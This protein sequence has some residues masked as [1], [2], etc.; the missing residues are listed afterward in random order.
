MPKET[1][2][3]KGYHAHIYFDS[4]TAETARR[5]REE[6][7]RRFDIEMGRFH[8]KPVGPHP[9]FSYQVAFAPELFGT[10]IPWLALNR[11]GLTV[12]VHAETGDELRDH[13]A[14]VFWLGESEGL[15]LDIFE[16]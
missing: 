4:E 3:I 11:E 1:S 14:H 8:E 9:R 10:F 12:F 13:T 7:E 2:E 15:K 16:R 5:L 6:I